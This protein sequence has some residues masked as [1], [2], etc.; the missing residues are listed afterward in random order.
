MS[1]RNWAGKWLPDGTNGVTI[2]AKGHTLVLKEG[3]KQAL[4]DNKP[5]Q[6]TVAPIRLKDTLIAPLGPLASVCGATITQPKGQAIA[7]TLKGG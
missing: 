2:T 7:L 3:Q 4:L 5:I 6:L 1:W